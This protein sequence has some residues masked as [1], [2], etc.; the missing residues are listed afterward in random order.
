MPAKLPTHSPRRPPDAATR[1]QGNQRQRT[2]Y[3]HTGSTQWRAIRRAQL[4]RFP[5]CEDCKVA[6]AVE[7]DHNTNDSSRNVIGEELSSLCKPCH[8]KR[9]RER[10]NGR[11]RRVVGCDAQGNPLDP[12]HPWNQG[13]KSLEGDSSRHARPPSHARPRIAGIRKV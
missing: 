4:E 2:R 5:L 7:V 13:E 10:Q 1:D 11:A 6:P 3:L 8:S 9:T 12:S